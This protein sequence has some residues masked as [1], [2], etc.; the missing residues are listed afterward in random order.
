M[1]QMVQSWYTDQKTI[2]STINDNKVKF[3]INGHLSSSTLFHWV[4]HNSDGS[5]HV[6]LLQGSHISR[7]QERVKYQKD[8]RWQQTNSSCLCQVAPNVSGSGFRAAIYLKVR[9]WLILT[10]NLHG[11]SIKDW[12]RLLKV[13]GLSHLS[14]V[15]TWCHLWPQRMPWP[16]FTGP[17]L[18]CDKWPNPTGNSK[19]LPFYTSE[20]EGTKSS[21]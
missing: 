14:Q 5:G 19:H 13:R 20:T 7:T 12:E 18:P 1:C 6:C 3:L 2:T 17:W 16:L 15:N 11:T 4:Y 9:G 21:V 8:S 10:L